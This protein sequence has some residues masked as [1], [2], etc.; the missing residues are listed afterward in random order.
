MS[1]KVYQLFC[2]LFFVCQISIAQ[3]RF[4]VYFDTNK[5]TLTKAQDLKLKN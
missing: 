1:T 4:A 5:S 3:E 2:V